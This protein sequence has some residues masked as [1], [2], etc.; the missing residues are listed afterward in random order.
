MNLSAFTG[1]VCLGSEPC[2]SAADYAAAGH[3]QPW[4]PSAGAAAGG[5][6]CPIEGR[7]C[8]VSLGRDPAV[9]CTHEHRRHLTPCLM[10]PRFS[11]ATFSARH[12]RCSGSIGEEDTVLRH[13]FGG[14][15]G[16]PLLR[17]GVFV[18]LGAND[19]RKGTNTIFLEHCLGW[20]GLL[21]EGQP[22]TFEKL[23]AFRRAPSA[24]KL[25][26]AV[27]ET[28]GHIDFYNKSQATAGIPSLMTVTHRR[29][30]HN[31]ADSRALTSVP[32]GPLG[33]WLRLLGVAQVDLFVLDVEGA[34][35]MVLRSLDWARL[36]VRVLLAECHAN[37]CVHR[38]D[39][40][41][42]DYLRGAA[43]LDRVGVLR[44]R[45]DIW[46]AVYVSWPLLTAASPRLDVPFGSGAVQPPPKTPHKK[47]KKG[48]QGTR[49]V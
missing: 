2:V 1:R 38:R 34:E 19:G 35:L 13:F 24:A 49:R 9:N 40:Q 8:E 48:K 44:A 46:D 25:A 39:E 26:T 28:H 21:I 36:R 3:A 16:L 4:P 30:W 5:G 32:C 20:R 14:A 23:R 27:C 17:G 45:D 11:P 7:R 12:G 47:G 37:G 33:D 6:G 31:R 29:R 43:N 15:A 10:P 42:R 41:V 18:E 22:T